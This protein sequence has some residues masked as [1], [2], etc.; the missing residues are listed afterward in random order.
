[1]FVSYVFDPEPRWQWGFRPVKALSTMATFYGYTYGWYSSKP[2]G[3]TEPQVAGK[4]E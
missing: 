2:A 1:M 4:A 3:N